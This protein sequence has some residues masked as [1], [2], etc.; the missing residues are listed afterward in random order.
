[1]GR[2]PRGSANRCGRERRCGARGAHFLT[3]LSQLLGTSKQ[4]VPLSIGVTL[5]S[6]TQSFYF[7]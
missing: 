6:N 2:T 1:M 7:T 4:D 3:V 5:Q